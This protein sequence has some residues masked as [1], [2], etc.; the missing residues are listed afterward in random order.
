MSGADRGDY[1]AQRVKALELAILDIDAHAHAMGSDEDGFNSGGYIISIGSLHRALGLL[2]RT[3]AKPREHAVMV[4][5][6]HGQDCEGC[7]H[8]RDVAFEAIGAGWRPAA[9]N[10]S[11]PPVASSPVGEET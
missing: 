7:L 8:L 6:A 9:G 11:Y 10:E 2:G 3:A 1:L 5:L 4:D